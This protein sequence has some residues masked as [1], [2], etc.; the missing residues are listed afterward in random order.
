VVAVNDQDNASALEDIRGSLGLISLAQMLS[1]GRR[2]KPLK[3]D[4]VKATNEA[5]Q[6]GTY[7]HFKSLY[8]ITAPRLDAPTAAFV[9][10]VWSPEGQ[11]VL[12]AAGHLVVS[13][14]DKPNM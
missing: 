7:P 1:E 11:R 9:H 5:L 8:L 12:S 3:L 14:P 6:A 10:F 13:A 4:G 2:L